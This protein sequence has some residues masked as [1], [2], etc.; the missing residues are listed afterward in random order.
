MGRTILAH[1]AKNSTW[2]KHKYSKRVKTPN[3]WGYV[4]NNGSHNT[5][6][7]KPSLDG[8]KELF[9]TK[10][11]KEDERKE[12]Y[13]R[14]KVED[15]YD[16]GLYGARKNAETPESAYRISK[17]DVLDNYNP[18]A[19][20]YRNINT[21]DARKVQRTLFNTWKAS[22]DYER[23]TYGLRLDPD[24][25]K[26]S[27]YEARKR[28]DIEREKRASEKG[29]RIGGEGANLEA[30]RERYQ[31]YK[32][33][34]SKKNQNL[35]DRGYGS[36]RD[37]RSGGMG[38]ASEQNHKRYLELWGDPDFK[39]YNGIKDKEKAA[40]K[41][42]ESV[43]FGEHS[44]NPEY[45]KKAKEYIKY[46]LGVDPSTVKLVF[47]NAQGK[48][49]ILHGDTA[50]NNKIYIAHS[51]KDTTWKKENPKYVKRVGTPPNAYYIY[52]N[53]SHSTG[54]KPGTRNNKTSGSDV[55][56]A[57]RNAGST[58]GSFIAETGQE[59]VN[60]V[61]NAINATGNYIKETAIETR[62]QAQAY[63][64]RKADETKAAYN[65]HANAAKQRLNQMERSARKTA[66][67]AKRQID[68]AVNEANNQVN[69][70]KNS[71]MHTYV[72]TKA[73]VARTYNNTKEQATNSYNRAVGEARAYGK[74]AK[75]SA[76]NTRNNLQRSAK[77]AEQRFEK[78]VND[79]IAS[80]RNAYNQ[81]VNSAR[82]NINKAKNYLN[83]Q[84]ARLQNSY[85]D[86]VGYAQSEYN[87]I[88]KE[89]ER[90]IDA[91]EARAN[92]IAGASKSL[93]GDIGNAGKKWKE[94][95]FHDGMYNGTYIIHKVPNEPELVLRHSGLGTTW[96]KKNHKYIAKLDGQY[97]YTPEELRAYTSGARDK[98]RGLA[99]KGK[100][101]WDKAKEKGSEYYE[102]GKE[103]A[104]EG[105]S[106]GKAA[107][108]RSSR[109]SR[110]NASHMVDDV[111]SGR[112][113]SD[114]KPINKSSYNNKR[115]WS[116][117]RMNSKGN[118]VSTRT[119]DMEKREA[120]TK[121]YKNAKDSDLKRRKANREKRTNLR[122]RG[123]SDSTKVKSVFEGNVYLDRNYR[124]ELMAD[125]RNLKKRGYSSSRGS[126]V[127][128]NLSPDTV[129]YGKDKAYGTQ[130]TADV[131]RAK[132]MSRMKAA[133]ARS[134]KE[135]ASLAKRRR[136]NKTH[137]Y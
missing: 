55:G 77:A 15:A 47:K 10:E 136:R 21:D 60:S 97:F 95:A 132:A 6:S 64:N 130:K 124:N 78:G 36:S 35:K 128:P 63:I 17:Y 67:D 13:I 112:R 98:A 96:E 11:Q 26:N 126:N 133:G 79:T 28:R 1:S 81:G 39:K 89:A 71:A 137:G 120:N 27:G 93:L 8:V 87:R 117:V 16:S 105:Y 72:N 20:E 34:Q 4:Y 58:T 70:V 31:E 23:K 51:A 30:R 74:R 111:A 92:K 88:L 61:G 44:N 122:D 38:L 134:S 121:D 65:R 127:N 69:R 41:V 32:D 66:D 40:E 75:E 104:E 45:K 110:Y 114:E 49:M 9:K 101:Y 18:I 52:N 37:K 84:K 29:S 123:Y 116:N 2:E 85:N 3:G 14:S 22:D 113:E 102:K 129:Q 118:K 94:S 135:L 115:V 25:I 68:S 59:V 119:Y 33:E 73:N 90:K 57:W 12:R 24:E 131:N 56:D 80:A 100:E 106:K 82:Y 46:V 76:I 62:D 107:L 42:L 53:G 83:T 54:P 7:M 99:D 86:A 50:M 48:E 125:D 91:I 108:T 19:Y 109:Q 103:K 43:H 5:V